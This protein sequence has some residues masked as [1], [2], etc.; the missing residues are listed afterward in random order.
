MRRT[1]VGHGGVISQGYDKD[2][3]SV[4]TAEFHIGQRAE[5]L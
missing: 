4:N 2:Q 1:G 5:E 3:P